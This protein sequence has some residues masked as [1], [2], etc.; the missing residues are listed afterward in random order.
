MP[1]LTFTVLPAGV[2]QL[3]DLLSCLTKFDENISLEA[4]NNNVSYVLSLVHNNPADFLVAHLKSE[5]LQNGIFFVY[6]KRDLLFC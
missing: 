4:Y 1:T 5:H 6:S 3:H 2:A